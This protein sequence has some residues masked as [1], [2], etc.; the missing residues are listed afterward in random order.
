MFQQDLNSFFDLDEGAVEVLLDSDTIL[1]RF[2]RRLVQYSMKGIEYSGV[3]PTL[4]AS[5]E[6]IKGHKWRVVEIDGV[7]YKI[8][9]I[10][11]HS[12]FM[13]IAI[14]SEEP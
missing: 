14:L 12:N 1:G 10:Q 2:Q 8:V 13:S 11:K 4:L 9:D 6:D 7:S 3:K 5:D